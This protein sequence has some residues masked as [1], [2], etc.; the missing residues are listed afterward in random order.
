MRNTVAFDQ[1]PHCT[2]RRHLGVLQRKRQN[3]K[4]WRAGCVVAT[5]VADSCSFTRASELLRPITPSMTRENS[6]AHSGGLQTALHP[7]PTPPLSTIGVIMRQS[8]TLSCCF[9]CHVGSTVPDP[10]SPRHFCPLMYPTLLPTPRA[11]LGQAIPVLS[12][13]TPD[14][15]IVIFPIYAL[16]KNAIVKIQ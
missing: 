6:I 5:E 1:Q 15:D 8:K 4:I 16:L 7:K 12:R 3:K 2:T 13:D 10:N 9:V 11:K 14:A